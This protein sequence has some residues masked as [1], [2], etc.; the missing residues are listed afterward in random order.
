MSVAIDAKT[1]RIFWVY[2]HAVSPDYKVC[3]GANNRGLA[4]RGDTLFMGTL[5]AHL[6]AIDA[7]TGRVKW[8]VNVG[9]FAHGY[10]VGLAP[11]VI[12]DKV[13][14]GVGGG[15]F[16]IPGFIAAYDAA[17]GREAWRFSTIPAPG[18]AWIRDVEW[19][20]EQGRLEERRRIRV[21]DRFLR[22]GVE[23]D[24]LGDW[25]SRS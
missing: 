10:S 2:K 1:G 16:G 4:I 8:N 13:V 24:L 9:E 20:V 17:T 3:C 15:G 18:R 12:K 19:S 7:K 5:D 22:P 21:G 25:E 6:V 23:P 14:I 11:L